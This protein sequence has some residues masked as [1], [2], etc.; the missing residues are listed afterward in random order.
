MMIRRNEYPYMHTIIKD[1]IIEAHHVPENLIK[2]SPN[3]PNVRVLF[4][5]SQIIILL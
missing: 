4:H 3:A 2:I 1:D 5:R